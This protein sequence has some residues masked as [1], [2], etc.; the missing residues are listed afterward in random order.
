LHELDGRQ[1]KVQLLL[2]ML[3]VPGHAQVRVAANHAIRWR[4]LTQDEVQQR[5]LSRA[6]GP[7]DGQ[8]RLQVQAK[9]QILVQKCLRLGIPAGQV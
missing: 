7:Q 8:S 4:E 3:V 2:Q 9:L 6:V 5:A 1:L